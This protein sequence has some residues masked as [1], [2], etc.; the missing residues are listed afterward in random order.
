MGIW[1]HYTWQVIFSVLYQHT[2]L[3]FLFIS[4]Q[5]WTFGLKRRGACSQVTLNRRSQPKAHLLI[6]ETALISIPPTSDKNPE[7][8]Y[9]IKAIFVCIR[10]G[11][12]ALCLKGNW[13]CPVFLSVI[14]HLRRPWTI[15]LDSFCI[16][17][18]GGYGVCV[19]CCGFPSEYHIL[20]DV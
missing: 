8:H 7:E 20:C 16:R 14:G 12:I 9:S 2:E 19:L 3:V 1:Y 13:A 11:W 5:G 6:K 15:I 17:T 18:E 10:S 4:D